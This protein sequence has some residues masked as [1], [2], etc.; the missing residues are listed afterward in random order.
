MSN[1]FRQAVV[2]HS[3]EQMFDLVCDVARYPEFIEACEE[4]RLLEQGEG[5]VHARLGF[6]KG[7]MRQ[8]FTTKN[9]LFPYEKIELSLVDGPFHHLQGSWQFRETS[10]GTEVTFEVDFAVKG[11]I[12]ARLLEPAFEQLIGKML[13]AFCERAEQVYG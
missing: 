6:V 7:A 11:G 13:R 10:M 3:P 4:G 8:S 9:T 12:V 2:P 1:V 5:Y